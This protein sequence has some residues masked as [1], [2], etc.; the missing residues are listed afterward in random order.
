MATST[1]PFCKIIILLNDVKV[2]SQFQAAL[3]S[4]LMIGVEANV[5]ATSGEGVVASGLDLQNQVG[6][7][8]F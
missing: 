1:S 8:N 7:F 6:R 4:N 3:I 5:A 2:S